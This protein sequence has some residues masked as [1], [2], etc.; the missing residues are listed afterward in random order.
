MLEALKRQVE[1]LNAFAKSKVAS[2]YVQASISTV[3]TFAT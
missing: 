1:A 3:A 2:A